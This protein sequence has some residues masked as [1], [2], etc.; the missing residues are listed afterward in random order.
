MRLFGFTLRYSLVLNEFSRK[1]EK[2]KKKNGERD[3][4]MRAR[5]EKQCAFFARRKFLANVNSRN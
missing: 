5:R 4:R 3:K 1:E 2:E